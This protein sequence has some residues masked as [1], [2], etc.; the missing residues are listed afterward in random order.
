MSAR[1]ELGEYLC[2]SQLCRGRDQNSA[3]G[4]LYKEGSRE[5]E[6]HHLALAALNND[7]LLLRGGSGEHNLCMILEDVIQLLC[8]QVLEVTTMH[9]TGLGV[10]G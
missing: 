10:S 4:Q 1:N 6:E 2:S 5:D 3:F 9:H 7:Q 8:A